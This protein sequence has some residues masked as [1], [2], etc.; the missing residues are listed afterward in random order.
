MQDP[1]MQQ[2]NIMLVKVDSHL[3][4]SGDTPN[5]I[6]EKQMIPFNGKYALVE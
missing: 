6:D 5:L 2:Q 4:L 1:S 3:F